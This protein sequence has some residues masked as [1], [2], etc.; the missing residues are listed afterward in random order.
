VRPLAFAELFMYPQP[1]Q[2]RILILVDGSNFYFKLKDL[3][4]HSLLN[5]NFTSFSSLLTG[6]DT[7][8]SATYYVGRIRQDGSKKTE[9]LFTAQQKLLATLK[10]HSFRYSLGY[11]M[12]TEGKYHEKGVDVQIALDLLIATY[13]DLCD[14]IILVSS[15]TD[16]GPAIKKAQ[17]KGKKV[18]YIGF[19]HKPSRAMINFC[20]S[21]RLLTKEEI[22]HLV[23]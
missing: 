12:K 3:N 18:E 4:L 10:K 11:L 14:K 5:F 9:K 1:M 8:V 13:E 6:S 15:D 23:E 20:S 7:L 17:Q 19:S 2:K 22:S 21:H 16:L